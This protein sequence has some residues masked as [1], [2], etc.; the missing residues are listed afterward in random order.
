[1]DASGWKQDVGESCCLSRQEVLACGDGA[2]G[3]PG[4]PP[5]LCRVPADLPALTGVSQVLAKGRPVPSN[6][7]GL[8]ASPLG[9][10]VP[11][12]CRFAAPARA[13]GGSWQ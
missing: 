13:R 8:I 5:A 2:G 6:P 10:A 1:M 7:P 11:D 9:L 12:S 4:G 3:S